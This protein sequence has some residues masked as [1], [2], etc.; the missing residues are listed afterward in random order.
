MVDQPGSIIAVSETSLRIGIFLIAFA[1]FSTLEAILPK[2]P[3]LQSRTRRWST[4]IA[5]VLM[6]TLLVRVL[7]IFAPALAMTAG[8]VL[9]ADLELGLFHHIDLPAWIEIALAIALLDLAV[10][11]Q[12]LISHKVPFLWRIHRVHH[13]DRD[14]DASSALRFHPV[15]IAL[16]AA[17]K[18][19]VVLLIGPAIIAV[20]LFEIVLNASAMFNHANMA[21]PIWLDK[22]M[23][24]VLVTP[25][26]HRVHHSVHRAEHDSN[27]G[28]CLSV[29]DRIFRTY[30]P[31]PKDGHAAMTI[32]L[33]KY[34]IPETKG[35]IWSLWFP[36]K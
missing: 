14:L 24:S 13:A 6:S 11:L 20:I 19:I 1:A 15:E 21:M 10:W 12:H 30:T 7:A 28:F 2:R 18:L 29:W 34:Q 4:N 35:L 36:A 22:I 25:D 26:M 16:S 5:M 23:R 3:R 9:A 8:A 17:Y 32:G 31:Q 33:K 27:Y